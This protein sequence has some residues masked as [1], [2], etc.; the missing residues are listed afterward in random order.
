MKKQKCSHSAFTL[1]ELL[2]VIAIIGILAAMLMPVLVKVKESAKV[3]KAQVE[4]SQLAQ[5]IHSYYSANGRYPVS[6]AV[7]NVAIAEQGK[8]SNDG[9]FTYG[10]AALQ[11]VLGNGSWTTNNSEVIA[12]LMDLETY[13][14]G[15]GNTVNKGH[16]KNTQQTKFLNA[17]MVDAVDLPGVGPDLV[18]R[19]P[20]GNPY[21]ISLDLNGDGKCKGAFYRLDNVSKN[22]TAGYNGLINPSGVA[23]NFAYNGGEMVWSLGPDKGAANTPG[24]NAS[25]SPNKDNVLSWK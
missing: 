13:P 22:G 1:I 10:G 6:A 25:V 15:S 14:D 18:Y 9:D 7:I 2:V 12:I 3:G 24:I 5:A 11:T 23:D 20:W 17:T 21:I 19:D 8:N 4:M 16:V